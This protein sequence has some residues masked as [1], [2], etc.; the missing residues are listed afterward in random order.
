MSRDFGLHF[1]N[2]LSLLG[3]FICCVIGFQLRT[4][5][6]SSARSGIIISVHKSRIVFVC[7]GTIIFY[8]ESVVSNLISNIASRGDGIWCILRRL[9]G[10]YLRSHPI[11]TK[12]CIL[13]F[14]I[15]IVCTEAPITRR[16]GGKSVVYYHRTRIVDTRISGV[17]KLD[18]IVSSII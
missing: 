15:F 1:C 18:C 8:I 5:F 12:L 13:I 17:L 4:L 10:I 11:D 3:F 7:T 9:I 6:S 14:F 16:S 2:K